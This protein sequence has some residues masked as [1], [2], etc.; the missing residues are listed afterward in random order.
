MGLM[1]LFLAICVLVDHSPW[2]R[3]PLV[4]GSVAVELFFIISGFY[5]G[6][7]L[8]EK[9]HNKAD[10]Y[11]NRILRLFPT[12]LI[13]LTLSAL[14]LLVF[15]RLTHTSLPYFKQVTESPLTV[16]ELAFCNLAIIGQDLLAWFHYAASSDGLV[17]NA[18]PVKN[19]VQIFPA[20][21]LIL[22]VPAWSI[23]MELYF[24]ALIPFLL[25]LR[26]RFLAVLILSSLALS[27]SGRL[28]DVS[29]YFWP[30]R[31]FPAQ[32]YLFLLG[33]MGYRFWGSQAAGVT[34]LPKSFGTGFLAAIL[35]VMMTL[36][37]KNHL[38]ML[39][40]FVL[41]ATLVPVLF[42]VSKN[43]RLDRHLGELSYPVYISHILV[44]SLV[45]LHPLTRNTPVFLAA[46]LLL[47]VCLYYFVE[48]RVHAWRQTRIR[49]GIPP[50]ING[51]SL[52]ARTEQDRTYTIW[53]QPTF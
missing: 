39:A 41:F 36:W 25:P 8:S 21:R 10:F 16:L 18:H 33:V 6:M 42:S 12:Y 44:L 24:Y 23:A 31:L 14:A 50:R 4:P 22:V 34:S 2:T 52:P 46:T 5:M 19:S 43:S 49:T 1:R 11:T 15:G 32:L 17:F 30:L 9:Y 38:V 35:M 7:I 37:P 40:G 27:L 45:E 48:R 29:G 53:K 26:K 13:V 51:P 28:L 3:S 47:S 20:Y